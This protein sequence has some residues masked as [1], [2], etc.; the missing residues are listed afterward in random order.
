[1]PLPSRKPDAWTGARLAPAA[2]PRRV[3]RQQGAVFGGWVAGEGLYFKFNVGFARTPL[4]A[5][6]DPR[7]PS[8]T[9]SGV[10]WTTMT[11]GC[12]SGRLPR[13][14]LA[15]ARSQVLP[16]EQ[17]PSRTTFGPTSGRMTSKSRQPISGIR[18]RRDTS[19]DDDTSANDLGRCVAARGAKPVVRAYPRRRARG[20]AAPLDRTRSSPARPVRL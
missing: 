19:G 7:F 4:A 8:Q 2:E 6:L 20:G 13:E 10:F 3:T 17:V 11:A 9:R 15:A 5:R 16:L 18:N 12:S 14:R 1:M